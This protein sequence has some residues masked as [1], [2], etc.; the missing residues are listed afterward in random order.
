[1]SVEKSAEFSALID[2][3]EETHLISVSLCDYTVQGTLSSSTF[4]SP[5]DVGNFPLSVMTSPPLTLPYLGLI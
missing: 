3:S 4:G 2:F 5:D 1:V